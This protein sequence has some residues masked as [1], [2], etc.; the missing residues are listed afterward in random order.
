MTSLH[1]AAKNCY[2]ALSYFWG[3]YERANLQPITVNNERYLV[4]RNLHSAL[5]HFRDV[6]KARLLW[7]DAICLDQNSVEEKNRV[8]PEMHII[9]GSAHVVLVW[10]GEAEASADIA[11]ALVKR[12]SKTSIDLFK[13][14]LNAT[15]RVQYLSDII[16]FERSQGRL[17]V[18]DRFPVDNLERPL[19]VPMVESS[20]DP[21]RGCARSNVQTHMGLSWSSYRFWPRACECLPTR[22][23]IGT[24]WNDITL[25]H[26]GPHE[27]LQPRVTA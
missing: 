7:I 4:T 5:R 21:A 20:V 15:E 13:P 2:E 16:K 9:Y 24:S 18:A 19:P 23:P 17:P 27:K 25:N 10:I 14:A 26:R 11:I 8:V 1:S 6:R 3:T 12:L 22:T